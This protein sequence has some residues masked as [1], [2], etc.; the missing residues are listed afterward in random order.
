MSSLCKFLVLRIF[1]IYG[2]SVSMQIGRVDAFAQI[3]L[4][5]YNMLLILESCRAAHNV[6]CLVRGLNLDYVLGHWN[7][8]LFQILN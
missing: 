4:L 7:R 8:G 5:V 2:S 6:A 1:H 3:L